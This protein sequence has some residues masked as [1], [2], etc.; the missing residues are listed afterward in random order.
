MGKNSKKMKKYEKSLKSYKKWFFIKAMHLKGL[1]CYKY[2]YIE[3]MANLSFFIHIDII[4]G[5]R[6]Y[7]NL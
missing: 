1:M 3:Y 5:G 7:I 4:Y 6:F 2:A